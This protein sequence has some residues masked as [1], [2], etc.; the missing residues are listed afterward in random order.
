[1]D[2]AHLVSIIQA[3]RRNSLGSDDGELSNERADAMDHYHARP[4][5]NEK[6]GRSS[7][8]TKD[9]A[10]TVDWIMPG[11]MRM[12]LQSGNAV[13]FD[14]VGADD[15]EIAQQESDYVNHVMVK[16]NNAF[17]YLYDWFKDALLLK[18]GYIKHWWDE[19]EKVT[20]EEYE[21]LTEDD[22]MMLLAQ[23][24][25]DDAEYEIKGQQETLI[26][27]GQLNEV[28]E[29]IQ[30][31]LYDIKVQLT[32][33]SGRV[34][35]EAVPT[36]EVRVHQSC[37]GS[38]QA[39][40]FTEHVTTKRRYELIEMGMDKE[41]VNSLPSSNGE[42]DTDTNRR[43]RDSVLDESD[44]L[45]TT[46]IDRSMDE[47]EYCEAYIRVDTDED[48]IA[49]LRKVVSVA[50]Q[51]P[52]GDEWN[53]EIDSVPMTSI[54][55]KRVPH[56]HVGESLDD[57]LSDLQLINTTLFRQMLDN[58]FRTNNQEII[59]N[60]RADTYMSDFLQSLPGGVK[61]LTGEEPVAGSV[62]PLT[63][64][65][66]LNQIIPAIE[67]VNGIKESRT[68]VNELNTNVSAD[69]LKESNNAVFMEGI[70]KASQ[71][72]EMIARFF[73]EGMKELALRVHE[74][75]IKHQDRERV[76]RMR[77]K[78]VPINP[79]EWRERLDLTVNVGLG[80]GTEEEKRTKFMLLT[81]LQ[82]KIAQ[83][84]LVLPQHAYQMFSDIA[85]TLDVESPEKYAL[86]PASQEYQQMMQQ[87][88]QQQGEQQNPLAE[89]E[90]IKAQAAMQIEQIRTQYKM[91]ADAAKDQ[92]NRELESVKLQTAQEQ[93]MIKL[94]ADL[95]DKAEDRASKEDIETMKA[96]IS[97]WLEDKKIDIGQ[98]GIGAGM[99]EPQRTFD[100]ATGRLI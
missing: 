40:P 67:H 78:Y 90:M 87:R 35:I 1:M 34:M 60:E 4:Y 38:L 65:P 97:A 85:N 66:I 26:D 70:S 96:E 5:G 74:L 33:R 17:V 57:D 25:A 52:P 55:P 93:E 81:S 46:Y 95:A 99:Q 63:Y 28:G 6:E 58:I 53:E 76:V 86:D 68:G 59:V 23:Y 72:T 77:G 69:V 31:A 75:V 20:T 94:L 10:E 49:E 82:E 71:K 8:V 39:S 48:G 51:I 37:R 30:M 54:T 50:E 91:E 88:Q 98:P 73:A 16:D 61:R 36:E 100:P 44:E 83:M 32:T 24:E 64:Q 80:T 47:I 7:V 12:F 56:R 15:E 62:L 42:E 9:L 89:A 92:Y 29:P 2:D 84:G 11:L 43:A 27:S 79:T 21:G 45:E 18:N 13:E 22:L 19:T 3:Y 41:F 14:P